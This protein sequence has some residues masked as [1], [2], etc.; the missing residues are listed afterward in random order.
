MQVVG[1]TV[2]DRVWLEDDVVEVDIDGDDADV[3]LS[4]LIDVSTVDIRML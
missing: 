1:V 2:P 4:G 3:E